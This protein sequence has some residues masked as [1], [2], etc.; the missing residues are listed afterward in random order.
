MDQVSNLLINLSNK[1]ETLEQRI[2][3]LEK[4]DFTP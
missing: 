3:E 2:Q 1:V 4:K